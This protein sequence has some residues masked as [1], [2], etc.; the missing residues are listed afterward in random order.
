MHH[1]IFDADL[2]M[3]PTLYVLT[4]VIPQSIAPSHHRRLPSKHVS[5]AGVG[6]RGLPQPRGRQ[7]YD[8][9]GV[10]SWRA[11]SVPPC[12]I[13]CRRPSKSK[14]ASSRGADADAASTA[15]SMGRRLR[16]QFRLL[17]LLGDATQQRDW[18][19]ALLVDV[20]SQC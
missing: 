16:E 18:H 12:C 8:R 7:D 13:E 19:T 9:G 10:A 15:C 1:S 6:N 5:V 4:I 3:D 11:R 2:Q 20:I 14:P 17:E